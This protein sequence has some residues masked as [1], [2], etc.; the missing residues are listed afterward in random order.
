MQKITASSLVKAWEITTYRDECHVIDGRNVWADS[1]QFVRLDDGRT[2]TT[3][4]R[5][6]TGFVAANFKVP[7]DVWTQIDELPS[8]A[9]FIG[10]YYATPSLIHAAAKVA[11]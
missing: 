10:N 1:E 5:P 7:G 3:G 2:F 11:A 6:R 9:E 8:R 4:K